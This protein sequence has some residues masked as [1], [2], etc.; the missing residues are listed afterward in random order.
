M[1]KF[2]RVSRAGVLLL[3][4]GLAG[5]T[6]ACD[7]L[8][9]VDNP[10]TFGDQ[11][12][13]DPLLASQLVNGVLVRFEQMYDDLAIHSAV[14]TDEATTGHN[15][16]Q[17]QLDDLRQEDKVNATTAGEV[18]NQ[19]QR[20]RAAADSFE[21]RTVRILA[22]SASRNLGL[23]RIQAYGALT[24]AIM[25]E[26]MCA[27]PIDPE[28][29]AVSSDS[30]LKIAVSRAAS[31]VATATA[32]K[33]STGAVAA[34]ADSM[35]NLARVSAARA[36]LDLGLKSEAAAMAALVPTT[37]EARVFYDDLNQNNAFLGATSG[38]NRHLGVD[39]AFRGL[40]DPRV[41]HSAT[42]STGHDQQTLLYTPGLAPSFGGWSPTN[43]GPQAFT[44]S[45]S[46]R[47]SSGLEAQYI[48]AEAEGLTPANVTF[49]NTRRAV[50]GQAAVTPATNDE[51]LTL[52]RDQRRRDFFLDGHRLGDL[53][54]YIRLYSLNFFPTGVRNSPRGG[55]YGSSVCY[56]PSIAEEVANP[57]Y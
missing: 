37:F 45:T 36:L 14:I 42:A 25:G 27:T 57:A 11:D 9:T 28:Q 21:A 51:F 17:W 38:A 6:A 35:I 39:V 1:S 31:A 19:L 5:A 10:A 15:F 7:K 48:K 18:Y 46:I 30:L 43:T 29:G 2:N 24:Y 4:F 34:R 3:A 13:N 23:A 41:R 56:V 32:Y 44:R 52:L 54:R 16:E 40:N 20:T 50:G 55:T 33:A 26:F 47:I 22:D 49:L 53:R 8:L 12:L